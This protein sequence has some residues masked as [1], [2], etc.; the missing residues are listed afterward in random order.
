MDNDKRKLVDDIEFAD[1]TPG[2]A[3][4]GYGVHL[5]YCV[6]LCRI[7]KLLATNS[8][9]MTV[10]ALAD[11][12]GYTRPTIRAALS[13]AMDNHLA[14]IDRYEDQE[15]GKW[16]VKNNP[17]YAADINLIAVSAPVQK[18]EA[19]KLSHSKTRRP[20]VTVIK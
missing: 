3:T 12:L 14:Y 13:I 17:V 8:K 5:E 15:I 6:R 20:I 4:K 19:V 9:G 7:L 2:V 16:L 18:T 11:E 1:P 10:Q